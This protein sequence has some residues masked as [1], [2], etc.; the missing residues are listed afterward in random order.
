M[1]SLMSKK[2]IIRVLPG[3]E[4]VLAS[5]FTP[6]IPLIRLDFPTF[7]RP[8]M[9]MM[10]TGVVDIECPG[11]FLRAPYRHRK[12]AQLGVPTSREIESLLDKRW[13]SQLG[14][15]GVCT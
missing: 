4:L 15:P 9:A 1:T 2:F 5:P 12:Q 14:F 13:K 11:S 8:T 10:G 7:G 3:F 6:N